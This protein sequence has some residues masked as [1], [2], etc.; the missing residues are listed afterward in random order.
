MD[1]NVSFNLKR[2]RSRAPIYNLTLLAVINARRL[3]YLAVEDR[4]KDDALN[5]LKNKIESIIDKLTS[6][7]HHYYFS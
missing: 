7:N 5:D 6:G 3:N 1:N 2:T 4:K